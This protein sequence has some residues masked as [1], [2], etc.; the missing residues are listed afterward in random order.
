MSGQLAD[1]G[2]LRAIEA[3]TGRIAVAPQAT[4]LALL[5][6]APASDGTM[7]DLVE[8][9]APGTMGYARQQTVWSAAAG[10]PPEA[11]NVDSVTFGPFAEDLLAVTH[12]A[13]VTTQVTN[14]G[15]VL[16]LWALDNERV[17]S[18]GDSITFAS[19]SLTI[20]A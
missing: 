12:C 2:A 9:A 1:A 17:P 4:F 5:T 7:D 19:N 15:V 3:A 10:S 16:F 18:A 20:H 6:A 8:V 14:A 13:L 11:T